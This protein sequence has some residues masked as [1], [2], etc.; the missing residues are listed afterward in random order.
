MQ[1]KDGK[2]IQRLGRGK[3]EGGEFQKAAGWLLLK[4]LLRWRHGHGG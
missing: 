2:Y 3:T 1:R 4:V